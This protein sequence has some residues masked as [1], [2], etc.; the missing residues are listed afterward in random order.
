MAEV[1]QSNAVVKEVRIGA[2]PDTVFD[3][4]VDPAKMIKWMGVAAELD[5]RPGGGIR[6]DVTGGN[7]AVG[8]YVEVNRPHRVVFTWGWEADDNPIAPGSSTVEVDLIPEG[9]G[10]LVRLTHTDL[11]DENAR[12]Q[13][14]KGW[15]HY[16][17]RLD[18]ASLGGDPGPDPWASPQRSC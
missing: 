16:L 11:P 2:S 5:P 13:H 18:V 14:G 17:E 15:E 1:N 7:A 12:E 4:F 8:E 9:G 6:V 10:T 3:F